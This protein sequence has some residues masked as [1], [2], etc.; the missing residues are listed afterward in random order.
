MFKQQQ[1]KFYQSIFCKKCHYKS[2]YNKYGRGPYTKKIGHIQKLRTQFNRENLTDVYLKAL[3]KSNFKASFR[4]LNNDIS[5]EF[6]ELKRKELILK[7]KIES[8]GKEKAPN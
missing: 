1:E 6:V 7:R 5:Q 2:H 3:I 4:I 8:H